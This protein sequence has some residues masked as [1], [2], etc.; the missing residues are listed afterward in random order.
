MQDAIEQDA[1]EQDVNVKESTF[2][3]PQHI[4]NKGDAIPA[5]KWSVIAKQL[6]EAGHPA[7]RQYWKRNIGCI[8]PDK[9]YNHKTKTFKK[10]KRKSS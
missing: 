2:R 1:I 5:K 9:F 10:N 3:A 8:S 7:P 4:I 6:M